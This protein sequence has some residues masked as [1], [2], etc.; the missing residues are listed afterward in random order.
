M[1]SIDERP[2]ACEELFSQ[3]NA[4]CL[5]FREGNDATVVEYEGDAEDAEIC[6]EEE[7]GLRSAGAPQRAE[8]LREFQ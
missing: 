6:Y 5:T 3:I 4:A 8:P 1:L 2:E 7:S